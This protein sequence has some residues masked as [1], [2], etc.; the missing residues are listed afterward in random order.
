[1]LKFLIGGSPCTF[2]SIAQKDRE[3][4][5]TGQGWELFKNYVIAKEKFAPDYFIYENNNSISKQIKE[6]ISTKLG[7]KNQTIN[8][9]LVSAQERKREYWHN[10]EKTYPENMRIKLQDI[11]ISGTAEREKAY[12]LDASYYKGGNIRAYFEKHRR[13]QI[14]ETKPNGK[15]GFIVN[16]GTVE[17]KGKKYKTTLEDGLYYPRNMTE[18]ETARL[19]T[20]PD[21]YCKAVSKTQAIKCF[22]N[23]WTANVILHILSQMLKGVDKNEEIIVLSMYDGIGTGRYCFD[24]LGYTNVKYYAYEID[25]NAIKCATDNYKDIIECGDAFQVRDKGWY[26]GKGGGSS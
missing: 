21:D 13:T 17:I 9:A 11:I 7:V 2:W 3:T 10:T 22:G 25:E 14:F 8:S 12:C 19:Q 4:E 1:M 15:Q 6:C 26:I 16:N 24:K 23:G 18:V 20:M 5:P